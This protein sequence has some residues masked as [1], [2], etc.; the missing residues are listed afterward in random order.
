MYVIKTSEFGVKASVALSMSLEP[1][2]VCFWSS[3][4]LC[5]FMSFVFSETTAKFNIKLYPG[6]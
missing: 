5:S 6:T 2:L 1:L 3:L 4:K